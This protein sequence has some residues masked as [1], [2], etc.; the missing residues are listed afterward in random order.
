MLSGDLGGGL[1]AANQN[2]S[3]GC[4]VGDGQ[5]FPVPGRADLDIGGL[6]R[7]E[8]ESGNRAGSILAAT[9]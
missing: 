1:F 2:P 8:M 6:I 7:G 3:A 4:I 9:P 5:E